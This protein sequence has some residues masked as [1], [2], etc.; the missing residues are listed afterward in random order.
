M[1]LR[2]RKAKAPTATHKGLL[3]ECLTIGQAKCPACCLSCLVPLLQAFESCVQLS[4][5]RSHF[6][7][8]CIPICVLPAT[9][10]NN[11]PGTDLSL[12]ADTGLNAIVEVRQLSL[13]PYQCPG[14]LKEKIAFSFCSALD[15][16]RPVHA[17]TWCR[18]QW[19]T[20]Y[21]GSEGTPDSCCLSPQVYQGLPPICHPSVLQWSA[22]WAQSRK[23]PSF[24]CTSRTMLAS[25]FAILLGLTAV[26]EEHHKD[27]GLEVLL[28]QRWWTQH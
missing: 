25:R 1:Y 10:S 24:L 3:A 14:M 11:V 20:D 12:G 2:H 9:I 16:Y 21:T 26:C 19:V 28:A 4:E 17:A 6:E 18:L 22:T 7:E 8:F 27:F 23:F 15:Q 13:L 5:A